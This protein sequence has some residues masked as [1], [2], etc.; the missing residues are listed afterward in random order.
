LKPLLLVIMVVLDPDADGVA[1]LDGVAAGRVGEAPG[2]APPGVAAPE[3]LA[4]ALGAAL[5]VVPSTDVGEAAAALGAALPAALGAVEAGA[6]VGVAVPPQ[7]ARKAPT[8]EAETPITAAQRRKSRRF[9]R[10]GSL[11]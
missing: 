1:A 8:A 4:A 7:A 3:E 5:A 11:E 2:V 9:T 6:V 10:D